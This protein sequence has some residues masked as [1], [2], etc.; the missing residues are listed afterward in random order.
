MTT[1]IDPLPDFLFGADPEVFI[2]DANG[3]GVSPDGIIPGTKEEP[4]KVKYGAV[5]R[6]GMAAEFNI[7]PAG[8]FTEFNRNINSVMKSL[9]GFLP[10]GHSLSVVPV[11]EFTP[12]VFGRASEEAKELGCIPD[13]NAWTGEVNPPPDISDNPFLRC[14]GGHIH[15]GWGEGFE[16]TDED[17]FRNCVDA[18][19]Q[20]D[21]F[22]GAW[23]V[24]ID[25]DPRRRK[26]YGKGGAFRV[27]PY[28]V[29]YRTLSNFWIT[30]RE[31]RLATWNRL[32]IALKA[33]AKAYLPDKAGGANQVIVDYINAS[34]KNTA[35][36]QAY[37]Y[38]LVTTDTMYRSF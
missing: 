19:K 8:T 32:Q 14:A 20:L 15:I 24:K 36:E 12:E 27:K 25:D 37:R 21:W 18:V 26:L 2:V 11:M 9:A 23:S 7:D 29:E 31:R 10:E 35:I 6:D 3:K 22:L 38:P 33:I 17:H 16:L 1:A 4:F 13:F 34:Q 28:G 30:T 5:Q